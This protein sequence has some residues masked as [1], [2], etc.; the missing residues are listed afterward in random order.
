MSDGKQWILRET[1]PT[2]DG[3]VVTVY[4]EGDWDGGIDIR[5]ECQI[6]TEEHAQW[7]ADRL[8]ASADQAAEIE[9]LRAEL[10]EAREEIESRYEDDRILSKTRKD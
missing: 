1:C 3:Y 8:N 6:E 9:R 2:D 7:Y 4:T 10:A 5:R